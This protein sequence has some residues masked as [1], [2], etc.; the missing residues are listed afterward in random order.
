L[1]NFPDNG[2]VVENGSPSELLNIPGGMF[3]R[4]LRGEESEAEGGISDFD[5]LDE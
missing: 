5:R 1:T 2:H 3:R 4:L